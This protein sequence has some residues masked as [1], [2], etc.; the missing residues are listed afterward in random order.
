M[1]YRLICLAGLLLVLFVSPPAPAATPSAVAAEPGVKLYEAPLVIPT[2]EVG[3]PQKNP[4][5]Y[6]GR[7]YQGAKGPVYPYPLYDTLTDV[8]KDKTYKAVYLEN[9]YV[10]YID[11]ARDGRPHLRRPR[12]DQRLRLLLPPARHQAGADRHARGLD[13]RRRRVEHPA[14]PPRD[15]LHAGRLQAGRERRR[16]Q[17]RLGGRDRAAAPHEV[18]R[19]HDALPRPLLPRSHREA[20]QPHAAAALDALLR[21]RRRPRQRATTRCSS[22]RAPSSARSTARGSSSTGPSARSATAASTAAA[23]T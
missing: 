22:R 7:S 17:D 4:I 18:A 8:R 14:P 6:S 11:P 12:Q 21:Q 10:Q 1:R 13:L 5:F 3:P 23:W 16:Q 2:Y 15:D 9:K 19:G 20:L